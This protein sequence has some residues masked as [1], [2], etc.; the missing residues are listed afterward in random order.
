MKLVTKIV[1]LFAGIVIAFFAVTMVPY[2]NVYIRDA[3]T[4]MTHVTLA[5]E[6]VSPGKSD[7]AA[8]A[9]LGEG[10]ENSVPIP[11]KPVQIANTK[12]GDDAAFVNA[13]HEGLNQAFPI[14]M[15][16]CQWSY[17]KLQNGDYGSF[18]TNIVWSS[19]DQKTVFMQVAVNKSV[20]PDPD[21]QK[22]WIK[23]LDLFY[24]D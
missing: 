6:Q 13:A 7:P 12:P 20:C 11:D 19:A 15:K 22:P 4:F 1:S 21:M 3:G 17:R 23:W 18:A 2:Y 14:V 24:R 10:D 5:G 9:N 8:A 16:E